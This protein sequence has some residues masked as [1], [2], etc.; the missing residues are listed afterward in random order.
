MTDI[1]INSPFK[2][3]GIVDEVTTC[4]CC[5]KTRLARTVAMEREDGEVV[6]YGTT[7]AARALTG[8]RNAKTGELIWGRALM[9]QRCK[10]I[11]TKVLDAI[12]S[13]DC[14]KKAAGSRFLVSFGYYSDTGNKM[15][16]RIYYEGWSIPGIEI[17]PGA[18]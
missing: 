11:L 17:E 6:H 7:C 10:H 14:P 15:P 5:G 4:D 2:L 3:L 8:S 18:Y 16:L 1:F 12:K 9:I 13:G